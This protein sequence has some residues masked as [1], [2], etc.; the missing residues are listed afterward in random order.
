MS[1][2]HRALGVRNAPTTHP[3][4]RGSACDA[5][6]MSKKVM[7][8][9]GTI[10]RLSACVFARRG[11]L[12]SHR[13]RSR[14]G[15]SHRTRAHARWQ[16]SSRARSRQRPCWKRSRPRAHA[17]PNPANRVRR[18]LRGFP[19]SFRVTNSGIEITTSSGADHTIPNAMAST[20]TVRRNWLPPPYCQPFDHAFRTLRA[21]A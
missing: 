8:A 4:R 2:F 21:V 5:V 20:P 3:V 7:R 16:A 19:G 1:P 10:P 17:T 18:D 6:G 15:P 14:H 12:H 9:G 11:P 13:H